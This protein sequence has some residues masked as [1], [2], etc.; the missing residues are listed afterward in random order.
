[1][2]TFASLYPKIDLTDTFYDDESC[3]IGINANNSY[4]ISK[5]NST[6]IVY[7]ATHSKIM[8]FIDSILVDKLRYS[9]LKR[10]YEVS[11]SGKSQLSAS[12][13]R[14]VLE[15]A[16]NVNAKYE[17]SLAETYH[18]EISILKNAYKNDCCTHLSSDISWQIKHFM[19]Y[20]TTYDIRISD[21]NT[22]RGV[23]KNLIL[24]DE[25]T[26]VIHH[27]IVR[28]GKLYFNNTQKENISRISFIKNNFNFYEY[29]HYEANDGEIINLFRTRLRLIESHYNPKSQQ[30]TIDIKQ[31]LTDGFTMQEMMDKSI[32]YEPT[33]EVINDK[34]CHLTM[35]QSTYDED[36]IF[37]FVFER[38][39]IF[40]PRQ[41]FIDNLVELSIIDKN[42]TITPEAV[43]IYEMNII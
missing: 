29:G 32:A 16:N 4:L 14:F 13:I 1:M 42:T 22:V 7:D 30:Y 40:E 5:L 28:D 12:R 17:P 10:L 21:A 35:K 38:D 6:V 3:K 27:A 15:N 23:T 11:D 34:V 26:E 9:S 18:N 36:F 43:N 25:V 8:T 39:I 19:K 37:N 24:I 20:A 33:S 2:L 31:G 41:S